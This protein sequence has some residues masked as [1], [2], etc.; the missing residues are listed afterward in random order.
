MFDPDSRQDVETGTMQIRDP[1]TNAPTGATILLAGPEHPVRQ[2][3]TMDRTRRIRA[4]VQK[5]GKV[6]MSDPLDDRDDETDYLVAATLGWAGLARGGEPLEWS[7]AAAR[8]LYT[9]PKRQWLRA[10]V[11]AA[12]DEAELFISA[13]A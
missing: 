8:T 2:K 13:C 3:L 1:L 4:Q 12:L 11:R 7:A 6:S 5:T 10:Q 9:D